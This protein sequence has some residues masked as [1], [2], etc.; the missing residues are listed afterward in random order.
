MPEHKDPAATRPDGLNFR[1]SREARLARASEETRW[2]ESRRGAKRPS[3]FSSLVATPATRILFGTVLVLLLL[4]FLVPKLQERIGREAGEL[5]G[6][7][8]EAD[9]LYFEGRVL[10]VLRSRPQAEKS[11]SARPA[12]AR[13]GASGAVA[14]GSLASFDLSILVPGGGSLSSLLLPPREE[15]Q[16]Q[17]FALEAPGQAPERLSIRL[18]SGEELLELRIPVK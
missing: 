4:S 7:L 17:R 13:G 14:E 12:L 8:W 16:E 1:Y 15:A 18:E 11:D 6:R 9:A 5:G 10:V 2:L 3:F